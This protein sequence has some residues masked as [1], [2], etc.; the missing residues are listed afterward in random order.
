MLP[1]QTTDTELGFFC[2]GI[3][4]ERIVRVVSREGIV[5]FILFIHEQRYA[6]AKKK[7]ASIQIIDKDYIVLYISF[8]ILRYKRT[9]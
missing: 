6:L 7:Q 1:R 8:L 3:P 9:R 2:I 5:C 4:P